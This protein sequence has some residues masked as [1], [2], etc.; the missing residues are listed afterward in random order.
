M[1]K[2]IYSKILFVLLLL[3]FSRSLFTQT[4]SII[5]ENRAPVGINDY[6]LEI[7]VSNLKLPLGRYVAV[8]PDKSIVPVELS[9]NLDGKQIAIVPINTLKKGE[10]QLIRIEPG[11]IE[12]YPKR[13]YAELSYKIGGEFEGHQYKGGFSWIKANQ[14]SLPGSFRDHAYYIKYEGPGWENDKVAFRFY[15]DN[16]NA[17][18]I[19]GKKTSEII[20]PGVGVDNYDSYHQ[21]SFWGMD[22][23]KVG[24]ALGLGSIAIWDG[25]KAVR[26]EDRDS[27]TCIIAQ[28]S[29]LRA[30]V[31]TIYHGWNAN[32]VKCDLTSLIT[33]DAGSRASHMELK[34]D[35]A[36]DN[37]STGIIKMKDT[38]LITSNNPDSK[39]GYIA[40]FGQQSLNKD[41]QGLVVFFRTKQVKQIT[42]DK[43]NHVVILKP[44]N[45]YVDYYFMPTWELDPE[46]VKDKDAFMKCIDEVLNRLNNSPTIKIKP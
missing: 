12:T 2:F 5:V 9:S 37:I 25:E 19:F 24:K 13:A 36:V 46:P 23:F 34:V 3:F 6:M 7:P 27:T 40:T 41:M 44:E 1:K 26:V 43:L 22:N 10:K 39:W 30:Q 8:L 21:M 18:D 35:A 15:L 29:K 4:N 11:V 28:D 20:L 45:G 14:M 38:E 42:E 32:N 33:L 17:I 16:R 31:K